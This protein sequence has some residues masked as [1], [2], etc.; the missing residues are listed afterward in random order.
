MDLT[1]KKTF[2]SGKQQGSYSSSLLIFLEN[3]LGLF[4]KDATEVE[5]H[6]AEFLDENFIL[7]K[8]ARNHTFLL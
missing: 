4:L 5:F 1:D 6:V 7:K 2:Q 3:N 8:C